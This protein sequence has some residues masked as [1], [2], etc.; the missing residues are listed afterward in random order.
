MSVEER[1][2]RPLKV[3]LVSLPLSVASVP[4][5]VQV[6]VASKCIVSLPSVPSVTQTSVAP[7]GSTVNSACDAGPG[8]GEKVD[9]PVPSKCSSWKFSP[10][11]HTSLGPVPETPNRVPVKLNCL[12]A[13][14]SQCVA[15]V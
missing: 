11:S 1:G 7:S 12:K 5:A 6:R 8:D 15:T 9:Q 13:A 2:A 10:V 14:P 3:V 4:K